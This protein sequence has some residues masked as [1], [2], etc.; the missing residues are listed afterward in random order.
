MNN[1]LDLS[2]VACAIFAFFGFVAY[3]L[4]RQ[5]EPK[6]DDVVI[7]IIAGGTIPTTIAIILYPFFPSF[8]GSIEEMSLQIAIMGLVL[9][10]VYVKVIVTKINCYDS[11]F[12]SQSKKEN[13]SGQ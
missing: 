6:L 11:K 8:I 4:Y 3:K 5:Q 7:I 12:K 10:F 2:S 1:L 9:L 13:S